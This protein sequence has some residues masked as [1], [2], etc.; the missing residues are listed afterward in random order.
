MQVGFYPCKQYF[1]SFT[2]V[3][4]EHRAP[5]RRGSFR[6]KDASGRAFAVTRGRTGISC[7]TYFGS[8]LL[9]FQTEGFA[10]WLPVVWVSSGASPLLCVCPPQHLIRCCRFTH[11]LAQP[12]PVRKGFSSRQSGSCATRP[13]SVFSS[14]LPKIRFSNYW[15]TPISC[16]FQTSSLKTSLGRETQNTQ[17]VWIETKSIKRLCQKA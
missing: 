9:L 4:S 15:T 8:L 17:E 2:I 12:Q 10:C 13:Y 5:R 11:S 16:G 6:T 1:F 3:G 14:L 7:R